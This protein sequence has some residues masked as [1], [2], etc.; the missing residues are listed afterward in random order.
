[1]YGKARQLG[2]KIISLHGLLKGH[3]G[4]IIDTARSLVAAYGLKAL[5]LIGHPNP[6]T[7]LDG[8]CLQGVDWYGK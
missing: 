5:R 4:D 2:Q 3:V 6:R 8:R 7:A 1:M